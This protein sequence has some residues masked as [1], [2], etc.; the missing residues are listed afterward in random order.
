MKVFIR[1]LACGVPCTA[2]LFAIAVQLAAA[3]TPSAP[4]PS[5]TVTIVVPLNA[6]GP[7]DV[8]ARM[9]QPRLSALLGQSVIVENRVGAGG[10]IGNEYVANSPPD[11][12][13][14]V[15]QAFGGMHAYLFTKGLRDMARELTPVAMMVETPNLALISATLPQKTLKEFIDYARTNKGKLNAAYVSNTA[16]SLDGL[17]FLRAIDVDMLQ[18]PF[19]GSVPVYAS[20]ARGETQFFMATV[21][22]SRPNIDAGQVRPLAVTSSRRAPQL[23]DVPTARELG[24]NIEATQIWALFVPVKTPPAVIHVLNEKL[25]AAINEPDTRQRLEKLGYTVDPGQPEALAAR[26]AAESQTLERAARDAGIVPQ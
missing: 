7:T 26:L 25:A 8:M 2:A 12:H 24:Y 21:G 5:R 20:L 22:G 18:V 23:P 15:L 11:G 6:G 1:R 19:N 13:T 9:I 4:F 16:I 3:Q 14:I 17:V 10:Y